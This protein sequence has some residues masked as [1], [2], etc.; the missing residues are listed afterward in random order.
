MN[1]TPMMSW[2]SVSKNG[3]RAGMSNP[4]RLPT[5]MP[6]T[7]AAMSPRV[8][9]DDVARRDDGD[10]GGELPAACRAPPRG[11]SARSSSHSTA[12]P[13]T[14]PSEADADAAEELTELVAEPLGAARDDG[15]EDDRAEDGADRV[16][17]RSLPGED[18]P[19]PSPSAG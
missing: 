2:T 12:A 17:Q 15:V 18:R 10:H 13:S 4:G 1:S 14:P 19:Q 16:D 8:V 6:M 3:R 11:R 7:I 5:A 9:A